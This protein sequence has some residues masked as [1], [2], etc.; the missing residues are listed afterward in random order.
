MKPLNLIPHPNC[1]RHSCT[2]F[3]ILALT[4]LLVECGGGGSWGGDSGVTC[5][6][7]P[8]ISSIPPIG[9]TVGQYYVYSIKALYN[10]GLWLCGDVNVLQMPA[11][12]T[13][14]D[15]AKAISWTPTPSQA[16]IDAKFSIATPP[17]A[18]GHSV[19]QSWAVHVSPETTPPSIIS[20]SPVNGGTYV[21]VNST[22]NAWF[23]EMIDPQTVTSSSFLVTGPAGPVSGTLQV[24]S[25]DVTFTPNTNL[26]TGMISVTITTAVKDLSGNAMA[27][28]YT[29]SF[30]TGSPPDNTAPST[31][32][33]LT[34]TRV[35]ASEVDLSWIGSFD[36]VGVAGYKIY[37]DGVYVKSA[38][39][40]G[41]SLWTW[42]A[43]LDFNTQYHYTISAYDLS[44]NESAQSGS[45]GIFTLDFL[46]GNFASWGYAYNQDGTYWTR[47]IPDVAV[48]CVGSCVGLSG[49]DAIAL[50]GSDHGLAVKS[51][52]SLWQWWGI[53]QGDPYPVTNI[54]NVVSAAAG[55]D[56]TL[57]IKSDGS[58]WAWGSNTY[59]QL[60]DGTLNT[61]TTPI[62]M[63]N[64]SQITAV[65]GGLGH[66]LALKSDG[67]V[68]ATGGNWS[69]QLGDGTTN[70]Q[71]SAIQVPT[72]SNVIMI[73]A[74]YNQS[75]AL[76]SDGTVWS[77]GGTGPSS[78]MSTPTQITGIDNVIAIAQGMAFSLAVKADGTVWSWGSNG[79]G[80]LGDG[81][82]SDRTNPVQ[83]IGLAN[84]SAVAAGYYHSL[85]LKTDGTVWGWGGNSYGQLGDGTTVNTNVPVQVLRM[86]QI[87]SIAAGWRTSMALR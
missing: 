40:L 47:T 3:L 81:T 54:E 27:S 78:Y 2:R 45:I 58:V 62:Q 30:S 79:S 16:N 8:Q 10:C 12:A 43:G 80:Q 86:T 56:H 87:K 38:T 82:N 15:Y 61:A 63:L 33:G 9:A 25:N 76:K 75:L 19:S 69:G 1:F 57:A 49:F 18:C 74:F 32:T 68:W 44:G 35:T 24:T 29:W 77:W 37:R 51:D 48:S 65:A 5:S 23:S 4:F 39:N 22:I 53:G 41:A 64:L 67:T 14:F 71:T 60:G 31:P 36:N 28:N 11:G 7:A 46:P 55:L 42:D 85:A 70:W 20:V 59:G 21:P 26:P 83:V 50:G 52:G 17:D 73:A 6:P 84:V 13:Y 34:A 66:T 72:L